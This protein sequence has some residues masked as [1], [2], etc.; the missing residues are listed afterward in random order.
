MRSA[1]TGDAARAQVKTLKADL[2]QAQKNDTP[3]HPE[4]KKFISRAEAAELE[5]AEKK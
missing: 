1:R 3:R 2:K 4:T 5:A